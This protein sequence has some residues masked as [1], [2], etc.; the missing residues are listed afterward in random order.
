MHALEKPMN[1]KCNKCNE[2]KILN[3][4]HKDKSNKTDGLTSACKTCRSSYNAKWRSDNKEHV[5]AYRAKNRARYQ[6][7][8]SKWAA[9]N[10]ERAAENTAKWRAEN[11]D[12]ANEATKKCRKKRMK[13]DPAYALKE[14]IGALIHKSMARKGHRKNNRTAEILGCTG[15]EF[16]HHIERQFTKG[17]TWVNRS[18]WHIDHIVPVSSAGD[19]EAEI[20]R[21]S[22]YLNLR[23]L[24][25]EDNLKKSNKRTYLI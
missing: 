11:R 9:D 13:E 8:S 22:H 18:K 6:L 24:W 2:V 3:E 14:R 15:A 23:P 20:I 25:A 5:G 1:K 19:D 21:L 17:M 16:A 10:R 4:F 12:R 7:T